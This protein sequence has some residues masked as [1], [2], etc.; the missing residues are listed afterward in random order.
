[1]MPSALLASASIAILV[2][3]TLVDVVSAQLTVSC[4]D[5]LTGYMDAGTQF[6]YDLSFQ[7]VDGEIISL[8]TCGSWT[9]ANTILELFRADTDELVASNGDHGGLCAPYGRSI[10]GAS[11]ISWAYDAT[12]YSA[13]SFYVRVRGEVDFISGDYALRMECNTPN[14]TGSPTTTASPTAETSN[15]SATPSNAPSA[16]PSASPSVSSTS[17]SSTP[18]AAPTVSPTG[19]PSAAPSLSPTGS[20]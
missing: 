5:Y 7:P 9:V 1:M 18:S 6:D 15:P 11:F 13:L 10:L 8:H 4:G 17:P 12:L 20:P 2:Q 16:L 19:S 3:L 14:P